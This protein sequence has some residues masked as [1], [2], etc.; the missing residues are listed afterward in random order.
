MTRHAIREVL[1][2][3]CVHDAAAAITYY[4][5]AFGAEE[6]FRLTEP[7]GRIGHAQLKLGPATVLLCDE[8]PEYGIPSAKTLGGTPVTMHLHVD[9]ADAVLAQA[10]AAGG[11]LERPAEDHFYGERSG[12][13]RDP[14]GHRWL[15][16]QEIEV[17]EV[18][19]MQKRFEGE[20]GG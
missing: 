4:Q 10:V 5:Q 8:Y 16:G 3:L 19:E 20:L 17:V 12:T 6:Q 13:V 9:D 11:T 1:P 7:N 2:Y 15:I 14:F 18:G